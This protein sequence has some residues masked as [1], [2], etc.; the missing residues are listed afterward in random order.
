MCA[1]AYVR[2]HARACAR[3]RTPAPPAPRAHLG[4]TPGPPPGGCVC[5]QEL[6]LWSRLEWGAPRT[7]RAPSAVSAASAASGSQ[8]HACTR[9][10]WCGCDQECACATQGHGCVCG[11]ELELWA[12]LGVTQVGRAK[13]WPSTKRSERSER[14]QAQP[15][16]RLRAPGRP[17]VWSV[18]A[19]PK[20]TGACAARS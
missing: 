3:V 10:Q 2:A 19:R 20:G 8:R 9:G 7:G 6:E 16:A 17:G 15:K 1:R 11:Q 12:R 5:G 13:D 14:S 4:P 18:R